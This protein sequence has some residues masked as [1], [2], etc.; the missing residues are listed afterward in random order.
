MTELTPYDQIY[1]SKL[2]E[3]FEKRDETNVFPREFDIWLVA[4]LDQKLYPFCEM[5]AQ[6]VLS[7]SPE[8]I[9]ARA[10][11]LPRVQLVDFPEVTM[12][13]EDNSRE[14]YA[15]L[16]VFM[17]YMDLG[18]DEAMIA[19]MNSEIDSIKAEQA[20]LQEKYG[21]KFPYEIAH[22]LQRQT[23][24]WK[25]INACKEKLAQ[26]RVEFQPKIPTDPNVRTA[27]RSLTIARSAASELND[28]FPLSDGRKDRAIF[29]EAPELKSALGDHVLANNFQLTQ[30][31]DDPTITEDLI[32]AA[33]IMSQESF[34]MRADS[35]NAVAE[36]PMFFTRE[37]T[38]GYDSPEDLIP[39]VVMNEGL[40][41]I[42]QA[43][44]I[45]LGDLIDQGVEDE[46]SAVTKLLEDNIPL[47]FARYIP[48]GHLGPTSVNGRF[49]KGSIVQL[50]QVYHLNPTFIRKGKEIKAEHK[51]ERV[52]REEGVAPSLNY[53]NY[54]RYATYRLR[55]DPISLK[56]GAMC[57]LAREGH[58]IDS[59]VEIL[60]T[61]Y[62]HVFRSLREARRR[63]EEILH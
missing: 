23:A 18:E 10:D 2:R 33:V 16:T 39:L 31:G 59:G 12:E 57:P 44:N 48:A 24:R 47:Q 4:Q 46:E 62:A 36:A 7:L 9:Q 19:A 53:L 30:L 1:D 13:E 29:Q 8:E 41:S 56:S 49:M 42:A 55:N 40:L 45:S 20:A 3:A 54:E 26:F 6:S 50:E 43:A 52:S 32:R 14:V 22:V 51:T 63:Q 61:A 5:T 37:T 60:T 35:K 34:Q 38:R 25:G 11:L 28:N 27:L 58:D 17:D 21:R 15:G